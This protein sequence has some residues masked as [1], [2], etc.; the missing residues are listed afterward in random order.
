MIERRFCTCTEF[1]LWYTE[2]PLNAVEALRVCRCGHRDTE[3]LD[4]AR[5]CVGD[6]EV[7]A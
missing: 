2:V 1:A 6:I 5:T 3:H 4:G 7:G